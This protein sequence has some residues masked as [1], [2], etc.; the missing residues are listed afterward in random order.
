MEFDERFFELEKLENRLSSYL[1][2]GRLEDAALIAQ[3]IVALVEMN[4]YM[5]LLSK[6]GK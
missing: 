6:K 1:A 5:Y 3:C 4:R 2:D